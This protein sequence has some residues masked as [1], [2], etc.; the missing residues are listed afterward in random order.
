MAFEIEK[1]IGEKNFLTTFF[2]IYEK[3]RKALFLLQSKI[4]AEGTFER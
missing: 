1:Y 3:R 2:R 4:Q